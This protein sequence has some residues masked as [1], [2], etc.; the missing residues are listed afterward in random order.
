MAQKTIDTFDAVE[1]GTAVKF[2]RGSKLIGTVVITVAGN[3]TM[4]LFVSLDNVTFVQA[5]YPN[6]SSGIILTNAEG[7]I[8]IDVPEPA[9]YQWRMSARTAGT[10]TGRLAD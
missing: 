3:S 5:Y 2:E 1:N 4:N 8:V 6:S 10:K 7:Q 9:W